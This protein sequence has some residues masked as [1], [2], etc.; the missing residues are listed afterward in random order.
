MKES[1]VIQLPLE[2]ETISR[3][4]I[5]SG[6][7][8]N[9]NL[10][11]VQEGTKAYVIDHEKLHKKAESNVGLH[12]DLVSIYESGGKDIREI[13]VRYRIIPES[14][15][16]K[17][18]MQVYC[19]PSGKLSGREILSFVKGI[20]NLPYIPGSSLKG[21]IRSALFRNN[22]L[23]QNKRDEYQSLLKKVLGEMKDKVKQ[24][25]KERD[26]IQKSY[27][28]K[29]SELMENTFF[30][31]DQQH[32]LLR[33][34]QFADTKPKDVSNLIFEEIKVLSV[35][36]NTLHIKK[37]PQGRDMVINAEVVKSNQNYQSNITINQY[38]LLKQ[39]AVKELNFSA[40]KDLIFQF[41]KYCQQ[42]SLQLIKQEIEFF[43]RYKE[44]SLKE[45]YEKNLLN[46]SIRDNQC[47]L[48]LSWG[49]GFDAKTISDLFDE[50][51]F[52]DLRWTFNL[53][54]FL[55]D[56]NGRRKM[57]SP[58]PKSRKVIFK[59]NKPIEPIGWI[60]LTVG[61]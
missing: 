14:V 24:I 40:Q 6:E 44:N 48:H 11:I 17:S 22:L 26:R 49:S 47:F 61:V 51:V 32:D 38:L 56:A 55:K 36:N 31:F 27:K 42:T 54:K 9:R 18:G 1:A 15:A 43:G 28:R 59:D 34:I 39:P 29:I 35:A 23:N 12:N 19:I 25:P 50:E 10:D 20:D 41:C 13:L 53:G 3:L 58:F 57:I 2:I 37:T 45:W 30:G 52:N 21:G 5:G 4:H 7:K 8:F 46:Y 16:K 33:C 60:K